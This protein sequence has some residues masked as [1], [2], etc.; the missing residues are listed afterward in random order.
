LY[1]SFEEAEGEYDSLGLQA[2]EDFIHRLDREQPQFLAISSGRE[3]LYIFS[4][5][6]SQVALR[7]FSEEKFQISLDCLSARK[8]L[9]RTEKGFGQT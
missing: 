6:P 5:P 3:A 1:G 8:Y 7:Y 2:A 9:L 4:S